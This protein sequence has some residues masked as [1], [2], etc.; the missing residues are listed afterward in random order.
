MAKLA[1][2]SACVIALVFL[3]MNLEALLTPI[4]LALLAWAVALIG[5]LPSAGQLQASCTTTGHAAWNTAA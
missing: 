3:V 4:L 5:C 2:T 1:C